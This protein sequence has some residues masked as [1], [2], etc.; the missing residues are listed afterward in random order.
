MCRIYYLSRTI[1]QIVGFR[2]ILCSAQENKPKLS[3]GGECSGTQDAKF[4]I[5]SVL[6][7]IQF[8][9]NIPGKFQMMVHALGFLHTHGQPGR[10]SCC[11]STSCYQKYLVDEPVEKRSL[12]LFF[13]FLKLLCVNKYSL[14]SKCKHHNFFTFI[15]A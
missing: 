15:S 11:M 9:A 6:A 4:L 7:L 3:A 1:S 14:K 13:F 2:I 12:F 10:N 5:Q 8:P